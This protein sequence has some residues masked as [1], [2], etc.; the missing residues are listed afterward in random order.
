M[1]QHSRRWVY[2]TLHYLSYHGFVFL[3]ASARNWRILGS[4]R[5]QDVVVARGIVRPTASAC[6]RPRQGASLRSAPASR[7]WQP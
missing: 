4:C 2:K 3:F 1:A 7:R 5:P 6:A